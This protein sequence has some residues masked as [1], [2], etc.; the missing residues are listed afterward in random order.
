MAPSKYARPASATAGGEAAGYL[1]AVFVFSL[2]HEGLT[3]EID[4][5]FVAPAYRGHG[6]GRELLGAGEAAFRQAGCTNVALQIG[7][8]NAEA[9]S[10]YRATDTLTAPDSSS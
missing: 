5:F 9:R 8:D 2:E 6:I 10:F 1:L 3:A 4:E 7:R